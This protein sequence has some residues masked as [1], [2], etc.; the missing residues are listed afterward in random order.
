M[1]VRQ[2]GVAGTMKFIN[3]A[4]SYLTGIKARRYNTRAE[5]LSEYLFAAAMPIKE[6]VFRQSI[7]Q[8]QF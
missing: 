7:L 1:H 8:I 4:E 5:W 3:L 2:A 6:I